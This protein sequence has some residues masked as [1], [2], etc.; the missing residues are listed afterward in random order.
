MN[1]DKSFA[2]HR[3]SFGNI[4][5]GSNED[6]STATVCRIDIDMLNDINKQV[7]DYFA[8][9][10]LGVKITKPLVSHDDEREEEILRSTTLRKGLQFETDQFDRYA[11]A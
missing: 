7:L 6:S 2:V 4:I 3:T 1:L 5:F 11:N 10:N 9:D 8:L